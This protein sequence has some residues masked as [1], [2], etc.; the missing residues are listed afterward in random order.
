MRQASDR[1]RCLTWQED[2][3]LSGS[4]DDISGDC[5]GRV[6]VDHAVDPSGQCSCVILDLEI[7]QHSDR[8]DIGIERQRSKLSQRVVS[9]SRIE[10]SMLG[11]VA[12]TMCLQRGVVWTKQLNSG[13]RLSS[14]GVLCVTLQRLVRQDLDLGSPLPSRGNQATHLLEIA[15]AQQAVFAFQDSGRPRVGN[16]LS[17]AM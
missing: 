15:E 16:D 12:T 13:A 4:N 14:A 17:S 3:T 8:H 9:D 10:G 11:T 1:L 5:A 6:D 7:R 2:F